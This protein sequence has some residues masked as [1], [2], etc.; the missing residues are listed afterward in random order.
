MIKSASRLKCTR[1][2]AG[3]HV[4]GARGARRKSEG[5]AKPKEEMERSEV[6]VKCVLKFEVK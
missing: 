1:G 6:R 2:E 4:P 3:A 5:R